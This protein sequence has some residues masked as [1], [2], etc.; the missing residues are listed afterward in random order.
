MQIVVTMPRGAVRDSFIPAEVAAELET[1]GSVR[2]NVMERNYTKVELARALS[3]AQVCVSGW[4]TEAL[5]A[6]VVASAPKLQVVAHTGGTVAPIVSEALYAH[7]VT[8]LSGNA[9]YAE[10]VAEGFIAYVL[11][12]LRELPRYTQTMLRDGWAP[13]EWQNRGL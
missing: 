2:W 9:L 6:D 10:S 1:L 7:G 5:D 8:V 13:A 12:A 4:G 3:D 11:C